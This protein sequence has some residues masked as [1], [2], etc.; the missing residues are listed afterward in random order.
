M[1]D[2][3]PTRIV[4]WIVVLA[5]AG[6]IAGVTLYRGLDLKFDFHYFYLDARY[7]W[8]HR[9]LNPDHTNPDVFARRQL[10]FYLPIVP[11]ALA[12]LTTAGKVPAAIVWSMLQVA[13]FLGSVV[14]LI[15]WVERLRGTG[16]GHSAIVPVAAAVLIGSAA[17]FEAARFN[18]VSFFVLALVLLGINPVKPGARDRAG[19]WLGL[20]TLLKLLP[21]VFLIWLVLKRRWAAVVEFAA[22]VMIVGVLPCLMTFGQERTMAYHRE[23]WEHNLLGDAAAGMTNPDLT[24]HFIDHRNQSFT[25]VASRWL[26]PTHPYHLPFQPLILD[27]RASVWVGRGAAAILLLGLG[28]ATW[29]AWNTISWP[30][31][32]IEA[33]VF[34]IAMIVFSPLLRQYYLVWALPGLVVA[35]CALEQG[36]RLRRLGQ[37]ALLVWLAGMIG[38]LFE[39]ARAAGVHLAML[40]VLGILLLRMSSVWKVQTTNSADR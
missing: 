21:A 15:R 35:V 8:E 1:P 10:P 14:L 11:L 17:I 29:R 24:D 34:C 30:R 22:T 31:R 13:A 26:D 6:L 33:S 9:A 19:I 5:A 7:V 27:D 38:W 23:W 25:A 36:Q 39:T 2:R 32:L 28:I 16:S 37:I 3:Q 4:A 40:I 12:P 20:A 18:Q